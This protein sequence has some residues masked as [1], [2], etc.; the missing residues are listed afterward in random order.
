MNLETLI[1]EGTDGVIETELGE[2]KHAYTDRRLFML[3]YSPRNL[4][5]GMIPAHH[6]LQ[7]MNS[8]RPCP[9]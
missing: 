6:G 3:E 5:F 2:N 1:V 8:T 9:S 4:R 7:V